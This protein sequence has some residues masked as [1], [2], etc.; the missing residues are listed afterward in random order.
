MFSIQRNLVSKL[1]SRSNH[2][3][4][5][6]VAKLKPY[7]FKLNWQTTQNFFDCGVFIMRHMETYM[8]EEEG[9][10]DCEIPKESAEQKVKLRRLRF[11]YAARIMTHPINLQ[12]EANMQTALQFM[13]EYDK[14]EINQLVVLG[15]KNRQARELEGD[16]P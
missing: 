1:L 10:Y 11:R 4:S 3:A 2:P 13:K 14:D 5:Q 15:L 8:G 6:L 12:A 16:K 9:R 7:Q